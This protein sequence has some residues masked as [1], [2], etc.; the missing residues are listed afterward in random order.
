MIEQDQPKNK[1]QESCMKDWDGLGEVEIEGKCGRACQSG[2]STSGN[3]S[4][5]KCER[6]V[7][8]ELRKAARCG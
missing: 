7:K 4:V 3:I 8:V 2:A 5:T 1:I 6:N